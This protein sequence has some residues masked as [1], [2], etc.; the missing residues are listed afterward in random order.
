M[1]SV[2]MYE[3]VCGNKGNA[4]LLLVDNI[5]GSGKKRLE[6]RPNG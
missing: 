2:L 6:C 1:A 3:S 5:R 4:Q